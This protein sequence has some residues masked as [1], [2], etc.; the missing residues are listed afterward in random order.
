[1]K[2]YTYT[3]K[4][5]IKLLRNWHLFV[6]MTALF[7]IG[8]IYFSN[9][10]LALIPLILTKSVSRTWDEMMKENRFLYRLEQ[11]Q[12]FLDSAASFINSGNS[13]EKTFQLCCDQ[14]SRIYGE[15]HFVVANLKTAIVQFRNGMPTI[16]V[17]VMFF[18]KFEIPDAEVSANSIRLM[19][20]KGGDIGNYFIQL[21]AII[22]DKFETNQEIQIVRAQKRMEAI[23]VCCLP[24]IFFLFL[25]VSSPDFVTPL[26]S[27]KGHFF[28]G[29][30]FFVWLLCIKL[31]YGTLSQRLD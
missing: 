5:L 29:G 20:I 6:V 2:L 22:R 13:L 18:L 25:K 4:V 27:S 7:G 11:Y 19:S 3:K 26:Y 31:V 10:Y 14:M 28:M 1:M 30:S 16:H 24:I 15:N 8:W 21:S 17:I 12:L 23:L 9:L